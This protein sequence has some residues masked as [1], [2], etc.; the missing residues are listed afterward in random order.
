MILL[1][2]LKVF[3]LIKFKKVILI[4]MIVIIKIKIKIKNNIIILNNKNKYMKKK[5]IIQNRMLRIVKID[6][7]IV[8]NYKNH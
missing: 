3:N 1:K 4:L 6:F 8:Q 2:I 5:I 7:Y